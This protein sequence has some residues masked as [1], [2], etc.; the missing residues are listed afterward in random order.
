MVD[1]TFSRHGFVGLRLA[2]WIEA[3]FQMPLS[4]SMFLIWTQRAYYFQVIV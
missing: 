2:F 3:K 4:I 1:P